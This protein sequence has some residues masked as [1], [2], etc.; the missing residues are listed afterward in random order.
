[1]AI[2][3]SL[4]MICPQLAQAAALE[5]SRT[6]SPTSSQT[7][8]VT[9][10]ADGV[11]RG[12]V[13]DSAGQPAAGMA[14]AV[15]QQGE[16]LAAQRTD[17][18]GQFAIAGLKTGVYQV[19]TPY[20][21]QTC[22]LWAAQVAPPASKA[23]ILIVNGDQVIR[24]GM[25]GPGLIANPWFLGAVVAAAIAIPLSLDDDDDPLPGS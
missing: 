4:A 6:N 12:T 9:L 16:T 8:D 14:I 19:A 21:I 22:R 25:G 3:A 13:V 2:V 11:L 7:L 20:R 1:M 10:D 23:G 24:G 18:Q 17:G 15:V 5:S